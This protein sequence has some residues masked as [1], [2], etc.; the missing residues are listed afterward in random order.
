MMSISLTTSAAMRNLRKA[1]FWRAFGP[2]RDHDV[3]WAEPRD[4]AD[5]GAVTLGVLCIR[6][7]RKKQ[8]VFD[9]Y[10]FALLK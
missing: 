6:P 3:V 9:D 7:S 8:N 1:P 4:Y 10:S 2:R 5:M